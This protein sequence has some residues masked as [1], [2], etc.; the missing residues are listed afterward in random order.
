MQVNIEAM[1][2]A[3]G[4]H[5]AGWVKV[6]DVP[7]DTELRKACEV[8]SC[9]RYGRNYTC[10]P[11]TGTVEE[12]IAQAGVYE[13]MLL[14]QTIGQL[15]DSYDFEGMQD[16]SVVHKA[17]T[18]GVFDDLELEDYLVLGAGGCNICEECG[19]LTD[20]PCRD[21]E[22]ALASLESYGINVSKTAALAGMKYINGVNTVTYFSGV[23]V[24]KDVR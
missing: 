4:A 18:Q 10:P 12:L 5:K 21:P 22:R 15:E 2:M 6:A 14:F 7:F 3:R 13:D 9:G 16:A 19:A 8:N 20:E 23:F 24:P 11:H 17:L 1:V